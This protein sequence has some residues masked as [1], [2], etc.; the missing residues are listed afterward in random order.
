MRLFKRTKLN[1]RKSA[2]FRRELLQS[3]NPFNISLLTG[4][5]FVVAAFPETQV[6]WWCTSTHFLLADSER[7]LQP[8]QKY[9]AL[10]LQ[11]L[12]ITV[13]KDMWGSDSCPASPKLPLDF[14]ALTL[15]TSIVVSLLLR[16]PSD[17]QSC[18]LSHQ[19]HFMCTCL[20][21]RS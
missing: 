14:P 19:L 6:K 10:R 1:C 12:Q 21:K 17:L 8:A 2:C 5:I 13:A 15:I 18:F 16:F 11:Q 7:F 4:S 3:P 20:K 9:S